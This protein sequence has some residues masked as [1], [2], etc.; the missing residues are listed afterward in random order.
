[1][2]RPGTKLT[3]SDER[4]FF[5]E[6]VPEEV[7][8]GRQELVLVGLFP[9]EKD[10]EGFELARDYDRRL[11]EQRPGPFAPL[12]G[13]A[14]EDSLRIGGH[15]HGY[16]RDERGFRGFDRPCCFSSTL[17]SMIL[18]LGGSTRAS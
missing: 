13:R 5:L 4:R 14:V 9:A 10:V 15:G 8:F 18:R 6:E 3:G 2:R 17:Q 7:T 12:S 1:M 11:R 16:P